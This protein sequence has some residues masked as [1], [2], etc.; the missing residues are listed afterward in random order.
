MKFF[1]KQVLFFLLLSFFLPN[2]VL[3]D[4]EFKTQYEIY[5]NVNQKGLTTTKQIISLTNKLDNV[6]ATEYSIV[7][8]STNLTEITAIDNFGK[9]DPEIEKKDNTTIINLK[10]D[11][12][13]IG[14]DK[15][16]SIEVNYVSP[17]FATVKGK[18]L[19]VGFPLLSNATVL[20]DY[21][22]TIN[23]PNIF[24]D[25]TEI[26]PKN[27]ERIKRTNSTDYYF[28]KEN[29]ASFR[30]ITATF[31]TEQILNFKLSYHLENKEKYRG[32]TEIAL[33]PDTTHQYV[34]YNSIEPKPTSI[35]VD[36][37]GNWLA[38]Y[39]VEPETKLDI[40]AIGSV[41]IV[42]FPRE[43][44]EVELNDEQIKNLTKPD[45]YW[46][47]NSEAVQNLLSELQTPEQI[48]NF[49]VDNFLYDYGRLVGN[50]ERMG[51]ELALANPNNAICMEFSDSFV[52][53][54]RANNI[55]AREHNGFAHT[56]NDK[57]KPLSLNQ[58]VLHAWPS[59]YDK[60]KKQWVEI[61][62]TWGNTT[63]G[64]DF[65]NKFDLD[66]FTFVIHGLESTY[67]VTAASYKTAEHQ[68]SKDVEV[69]FGDIF[70]EKKDFDFEFDLRN[71]QIAGFLYYGKVK[72]A[73]TGNSALYNQNVK[74]Q[75]LK[76]K[77][78]IWKKDEYIRVLPPFGSS[79]YEINFGT[80]WNDKGGKYQLIV[81]SLDKS[82]NFDFEIIPITKTREFIYLIG[83]V[84]FFVIFVLVLVILIRRRAKTKGLRELEEKAFK[85][86]LGG[87][88]MNNVSRIKNKKIKAKNK[89]L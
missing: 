19:E 47:T 32:K 53:L 58:D 6:Y 29:L 73:N 82:K 48:Y 15:T 11:K 69:D 87:E 77:T 60:D 10:F 74:L 41:K 42:Y 79:E 38:E 43:D 30:G 1:F 33:A 49:L 24:G 55:P 56:E 7:I 65:F 72:L 2:Y 71:S 34:I 20:D 25:P 57:L 88:E 66:H 63:G 68:D 67:P 35:K 36:F 54:A 75:V 80:K 37:D 64:L 13:L 18:V 22:V 27:Y 44:F 39:I 51:A 12:K 17:D 8:G 70:D 81:A 28:N 52:A 40:L 3:A 9:L 26:T 86:E 4:D 50:T 62:P 23:I 89:K 84:V 5:Y 46:E 14:T 76:D 21:K 31:G 78:E 16:R 59:Y 83:G 85:E 61:D 45:L